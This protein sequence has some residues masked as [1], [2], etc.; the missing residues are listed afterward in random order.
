M[1][2]AMNDAIAWGVRTC[3]WVQVYVGAIDEV[4]TFEH[5][6]CAVAVVMSI[7]LVLSAEPCLMADTGDS[8]FVFV[9]QMQ[10]R[11][12]RGN[13]TAPGARWAN[14]QACML[15]S[16]F[17]LPATLIQAGVC[18]QVICLQSGDPRCSRGHVPPSPLC[19]SN[20][21][22]QATPGVGY[23]NFC[24]VDFGSVFSIHSTVCLVCFL[25]SWF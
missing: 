13:V 15:W 2:G 22:V 5:S 6:R 8:W 17:P 18:S 24:I 12:C 7:P 3:R 9:G 14:F 16:R 19:P 23:V 20:V 11:C 25:I 4:F 21:Y 1:S 10:Q